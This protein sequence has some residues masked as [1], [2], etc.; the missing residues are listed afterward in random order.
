MSFLVEMAGEVNVVRAAG[1]SFVCP[2]GQTKE[3]SWWSRIFISNIINNL[4]ANLSLSCRL[5]IKSLFVGAFVERTQGMK[6]KSVSFSPPAK[7]FFFFFLRQ[8]SYKVAVHKKW[9]KPKKEKE[10]DAT[11]TQGSVTCCFSVFF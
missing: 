3:K 4:T 8:G 6:Y 2:T 9:Q 11:T 1:I 10:G 7:R 5:L